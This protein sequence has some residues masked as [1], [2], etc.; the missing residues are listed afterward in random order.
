MVKLSAPVYPTV[1]RAERISGD[2]ELTLTVRQDGSVESAA[3]LSGSPTLAPA[4]L[5]SAHHTQFECRKCSASGDSYRL[6]YTFQIEDTGT[7]PPNRDNSKPNDQ[8]RSYP[9]IA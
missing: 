1:A 7:C 5:D 8:N 3:M 9:R 6:V 4:A 2:V